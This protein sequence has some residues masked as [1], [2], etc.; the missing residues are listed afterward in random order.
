MVPPK[1]RTHVRS[2]GRSRKTEQREGEGK[3]KGRAERE[4]G[5]GGRGIQMRE[6]L[7]IVFM[8]AKEEERRRKRM[9]EDIRPGRRG[10]HTMD[11]ENRREE[12]ADSGG[13]TEERS[14]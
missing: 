5:V 4:G 9:G 6:T 12:R 7:K 10:D 11:R 2:G 3:G 1:N 13:T 14:E 8:S